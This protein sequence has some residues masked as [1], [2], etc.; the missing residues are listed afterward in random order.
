DGAEPGDLIVVKID[1][2]EP[3]RT[4]GMAPSTMASNSFDTGGL[5]NKAGKDPL[6]P[7]AIDKAKGVVRLDLAK[8]IPNVNW[9]ERYTSSVYELPLRPTLGSLG[10]APA[11]KDPSLA[12]SHGNFGG[13]LEFAGLTEG[14]RVMLPVFQPGALVF[15]GHGHARQ[16]DGVVGGG[17]IEV[18]MNV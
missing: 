15:L 3:A 14:A 16:G 12:T 10:V 18:P 5:A 9:Q 4:S 8:V 1:K 6:V 13:D 7:W 11:A 17:G 2:L